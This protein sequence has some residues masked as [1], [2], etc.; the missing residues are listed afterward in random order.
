MDKQY[1][2]VVF[3]TCT[4][5]YEEISV[6]LE[7]YKE[8]RRSEWR[9]Q[10]S[11]AKH[12]F[13]ETPFSALLGG[14]DNACENFHEFI[15]MANVPDKQ[16]SRTMLR[17]ALHQAIDALNPAEQALIRALFFAGDCEQT[18]ARKCGISQQAVSKQKRRVME[19]LKK[20]LVS[21]L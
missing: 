16:V 8:Y 10:K 13:H 7:V 1:T 18:Y 19:K 3:N 15:D 20:Y 12:R 5:Q 4:A 9:I 2:V 21:W 14:E 6:S 17:D 11:D